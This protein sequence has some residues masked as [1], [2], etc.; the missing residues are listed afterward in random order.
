[1]EGDL[2]RFQIFKRV[3]GQAISSQ[4]FRFWSCKGGPNRW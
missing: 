3:I 4:T 1:L 2:P